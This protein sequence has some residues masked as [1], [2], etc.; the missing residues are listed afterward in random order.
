MSIFKRLGKIFQAEANATID[1]LE[2]P[3]KMTE[4]GIRDL[5]EQL[6]Q[7]INALSKVKAQAILIQQEAD[8]Y[9]Q[10]ANEYKEK[11]IQLIQA[12]QSGNVSPEKAEQLAAEAL[13]QKNY[14]LQKYNETKQQLPQLNEQISKLELNIKKIREQI[15]KWETELKLLK[16]RDAVAKATYKVNKE[17]AGID[18][19]DTMQMLERMKQKVSEKE[20]LAQ[21]YSDISEQNTSV[22]EQIDNLLNQANLDVQNELQELKAQYLKKP[23]PEANNLSSPPLSNTQPRSANKTDSQQQSSNI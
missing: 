22:D 15:S 20:A 17:L 7:A 10:K 1:K 18:T 3:V 12:S 2:D 5:K 14:F 21:A 13:K 23:L 11:A 19:S 4:Q 8:S 6:K 9:L 16:A